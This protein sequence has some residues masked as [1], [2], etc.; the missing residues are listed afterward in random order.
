MKKHSTYVEREMQIRIR[1]RYL[2]TP[3]W[4]AKTR[5]TDNTKCWQS[6]ETTEIPIYRLWEC[7]IVQPLWKIVWMLLTKPNIFLPFHP[8]S[9]SLVVTQ[10]SWKFMSIPKLYTDVYSRFVHNCPN[11]K[12]PTYPSVD[13]WIDKL[14][15]I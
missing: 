14:W 10:S 4:M 7:K 2:K 3:I 9:C 11:W 5:I 12:Q 1:K 8:Q 6:C 15:Y 13:E